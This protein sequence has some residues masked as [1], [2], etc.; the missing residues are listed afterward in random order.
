[1]HP[2]QQHTY[3]LPQQ[4]DAGHALGWLGAPL[5]HLHAAVPLNTPAWPLLLDTL[6]SLAAIGAI[7]H[8]APQVDGRKAHAKVKR[9]YAQGENDLGLQHG[10]LLADAVARAL[11]KRPPAVLV[12]LRGLPARQSGDELG[13]LRGGRRHE[14]LGDEVQWAGKVLLV[15]VDGVARRPNL[16]AG[17]RVLDAGGGIG[18]R[19]VRAFGRVADGACGREEAEDFFED[20]C[21]VGEVVDKVWVLLEGL[22]RRCR[23]AED[24]REFGGQTGMGLRRGVQKVEGVSDGGGGGVVTGEDELQHVPH[25][26][27]GGRGRL[28]GNW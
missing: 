8:F 27:A 15:A 28:A 10:Q 19:E 4:H 20:G 21:G 7:I 25:M 11:F 24:G 9:A 16:A 18:E 1:M 14:A 3:I 12:H 13:E 26:S 23:G 6:T 5:Q 2:I 22:R 17:Q